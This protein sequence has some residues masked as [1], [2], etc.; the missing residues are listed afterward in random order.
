MLE[1]TEENGLVRIRVQGT[2]EASDYHRFVPQFERIESRETGTVP[3][4]IELAP[5]FSGWDVGGLWRDL[6]F[7]VKHKDSFDRIA[8]VGDSKWEE[9]GTKAFDPLFTADMKFFQPAERD[10]AESWV[11]TDGSAA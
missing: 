3:M 6:K 7:D 2:L 8:I 10:A 1:M 5:D 4:V 9:W 11:R